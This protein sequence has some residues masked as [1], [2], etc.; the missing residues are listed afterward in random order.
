MSLAR[1]LLQN[2]YMKAHIFTFIMALFVALCTYAQSA[3][4]PVDGRPV[5]TPQEIARKQTAML[6]RELKLSE[7]QMDTVY[8]IQLKYAQ[9]RA[10]SNTR[11][12][13]LER[14]NS[15][16]EELLSVMTKEQRELFLNKQVDIEP[17]RPQ[18]S[19]GRFMRDSIGDCRVQPVPRQ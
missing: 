7:A 17:R 6:Q 5:R 11:K 12:E 10:V 15:M 16:T 3:P 19:V 14:M 9:M 4:Q 8:K 2:E 18:P 1:S 13:A